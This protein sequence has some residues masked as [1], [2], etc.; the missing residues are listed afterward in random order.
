[1]TFQLTLMGGQLLPAYLGIKERNPQKVFFLCSAQSRSK[2]SQVVD[3]LNGIDHEIIEID[4]HDFQQITT[5]TSRLMDAHP[6]AN[7][8]LNLTC[9]TKIMALAAYEAFLAKEQHAFYWNTGVGLFFPTS[10]HIEPITTDVP[11]DVF[12]QLAGNPDYT[13]QQLIDYNTA[14][15]NFA[16]AIRMVRNTDSGNFNKLQSEFLR[17]RKA[18][19]N[20]NFQVNVEG[21]A[22]SWNHGAKKLIMKTRNTEQLELIGAEGRDIAFSGLWWELVVAEEIKSMLQVKELLLSVKLPYHANGQDKNEI[23][24]LLNLGTQLLFI[25]CKAGIVKTEN[26]NNMRVAKNIYGGIGSKTMLISRNV[27]TPSIREKCTDLNIAWWAEGT[28]GSSRNSSDDLRQ[29]VREV[30]G[31]TQQI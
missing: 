13:A 18:N 23:D 8:E 7:W 6:A 16:K 22:A 14:A 28:G 20:R 10:Q 25:E 21:N 26:I 30:I 11:T 31:G 19:K 3:A 9:G 12:F 15:I 1:M 2:I 5:E 29:K 27:P 24:I 17:K 4:P